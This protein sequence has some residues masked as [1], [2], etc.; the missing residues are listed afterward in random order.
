M[1]AAINIKKRF[2]I[3]FYLTSESIGRTLNITLY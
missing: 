3:Y 1:K 2:D